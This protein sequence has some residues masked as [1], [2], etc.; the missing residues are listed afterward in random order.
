MPT[1]TFHR[2]LFLSVLYFSTSLFGSHFYGS[3]AFTETPI[4]TRHHDLFFRRHA[5]SSLIEEKTAWTRQQK[6][7]S[8]HLYASNSDEENE[9][10]IAAG[11]ESDENNIALGVAGTG[12][13]LT[14]LYS[15]FVLSQTGC[16]LP[17]GPFGVVGAVEGTSYLSVVGLGGYSIF[18][19]VTTVSNVLL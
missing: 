4:K 2:T 11:E 17:A 1:M 12:A 18:Q 6:Q 5:F 10:I 13:A 14:M 19:K 15:E 9:A 8:T 3:D 7:S 16:G